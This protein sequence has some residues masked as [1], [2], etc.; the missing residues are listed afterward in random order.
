MQHSVLFVYRLKLGVTQV[1]TGHLS[2]TFN[3]ERR[4]STAV[5]FYTLCLSHFYG[6]L[7]L[8]RPITIQL[9]HVHHLMR[10]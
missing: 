4:T 9:H 1:P 6:V 7:V 5:P 2:A 8:F 10:A 3:R